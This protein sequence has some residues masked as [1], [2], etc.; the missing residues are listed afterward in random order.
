MSG[1]W[2]PKVCLSVLPTLE[3]QV[4]AAVLRFCFWGGGGHTGD[5]NSSPY[6]LHTKCS[7][8]AVSA[9]LPS[10]TQFLKLYSIK[11]FSYI[12]YLQIPCQIYDLYL[13]YPVNFLLT[14]WPI[15]F[16]FVCPY[17]W[18][19][20]VKFE[21]LKVFWT[22]LLHLLWLVFFFETLLSMKDCLD[23]IFS[24]L[25]SLSSSFFMK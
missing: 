9:G 1:H 25:A 5:L 8:W 13:F 17:H 14:F 7:Y 24:N 16:Q 18:P 6:T 12:V 22:S 23:V 2:T 20:V 3:L 15:L 10:L 21:D 11:L 4:H 19:P